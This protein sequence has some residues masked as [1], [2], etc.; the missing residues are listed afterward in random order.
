MRIYLVG[1][2]VIARSHADASRKLP[3]S[4][5]LRVADPSSATL[6]DF[7]AL[8][9]DATSFG[10][11][12]EMLASETAAEDDVVIVATPPFAHRRPAIAALESGRHVLCEKPLAMSA[13]E[14]DDMLRVAESEGRLLGACSTRFRGLPHTDAV[15][16]VLASG[17]LGEIYRVTLV[18]RWARSRSGIEFQPTSRW[19]LDAAKSGGGVLMDWGPYD[20]STLDDLFRPSAIEVTDAWTARPSTAADPV[21]TV[22]DIETHVGAT[23]MLD[24]AEGRIRVS[25]E[26][27]SA[28]HGEEYARAEIEGTGGAVHWTPFDSQQPVFLRLDDAGTPTEEVIPPGARDEYSI[29]DRP[30]VSFYAAVRGL[31]NAATVGRR[32]V[33]E[34]RSLRAIYDCAS[35]GERQIVEFAA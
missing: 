6:A 13:D 3:E 22:F 10:T 26:R 23:L 1:A 12:D 17:V 24:T 21:D 4:V 15:K 35:S 25:Y 30:L 16:R 9:P 28:T 2:G 11:V 5:E 8:Y 29:F 33:D 7:V 19:F 27:S 34:F 18:N 32:A 31:E 20:I 14:A